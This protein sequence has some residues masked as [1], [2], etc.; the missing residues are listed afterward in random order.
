MKAED[1]RPRGIVGIDVDVTTMF[2]VFAVS[3]D[4]LYVL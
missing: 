3:S 1:D 4:R 2:V